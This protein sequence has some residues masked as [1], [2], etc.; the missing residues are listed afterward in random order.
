MNKLTSAT[1]G[2]P[3][4]IASMQITEP[5][6]AT[7]ITDYRQALADPAINAVIVSTLNGSLAPITLAAVR[8][9]DLRFDVCP[10]LA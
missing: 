5:T 7:A 2:E 3:N 8:A 10:A 6:C 1:A 9:G 4:A